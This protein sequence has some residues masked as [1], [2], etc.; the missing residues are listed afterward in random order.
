L[1]TLTEPAWLYNPTPIFVRLDDYLR[2]RLR[3][4]YGQGPFARMA[5]Q[6]LLPGYML[7][8]GR[9]AKI[10]ANVG[11]RD[12]VVWSKGFFV[13][14]ETYWHNIPKTDSARWFE[15]TL[16]ADIHTVPWFDHSRTLDGDQLTRH[17]NYLISRPGGCEGC[18]EGYVYFTPSADPV[19]IHRLMQLDLSCLTRIHPCVD[20]SDIMPSAWRQYL[21]EHPIN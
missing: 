20:Q 5:Q 2:W 12:G 21:A 13:G 8:G 16:A 3:L 18:I 19:D 4:S 11:M 10:I 15:Y 7:M 9:P 14:I 6:F 17:P 1:I